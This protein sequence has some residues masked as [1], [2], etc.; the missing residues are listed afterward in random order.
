MLGIIIGIASVVSV[1][2]LGQGSQQQVLGG[3]AP[4]A[5]YDQRAARQAQRNRRREAIRTLVPSD[6]AA[7]AAESYAD[8]VTPQLSSSGQVRYGNVAAN[9]QVTGVGADYFR[10]NNRS[11]VSGTSFDEDSISSLAQEAVID[12]TGQSTLFP[13]GED[14]LGRVIVIGNVPLRIIGVVTASTG[15]FGPQSTRSPSSRHTTAMSHI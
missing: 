6:A 10:V 15:G 9:A 4:S 13:N 14:P 2:A 8:S 12:A 5:Q 1:V 7:I 3:S 11:F